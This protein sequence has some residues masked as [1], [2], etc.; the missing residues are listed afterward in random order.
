MLS[1]EDLKELYETYKATMPDMYA[2][3][4]VRNAYYE[5]YV[6]GTEA[7]QTVK[8]EQLQ[9]RVYGSFS[10][11]IAATVEGH[12]AVY[13]QNRRKSWAVWNSATTPTFGSCS[14]WKKKS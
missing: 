6:R 9:V 12:K 5:A 4:D 3:E 13:P 8:P 10:N 2:E 1:V 11:G 14:F 7:E